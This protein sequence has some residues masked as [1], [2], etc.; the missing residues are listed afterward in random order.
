MS[1]SADEVAFDALAFRSVF[2]THPAGVAVVTLDGPDGPTGFT[3]TSVVSVSADPPIVLFT[4]MES[5]SN[6]PALSAADTVVIHFLGS[7]HAE[8][9]RRFS[10]SGIDRF[11][12]LAWTPLDR[13]EPLIDGVDTWMR[14]AVLS[15]DRA[16]GS[17]VVQ[18]EPLECRVSDDRQPLV[19]HDRRYH[20]LTDDSVAEG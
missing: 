2:R 20:R 4:I 11:E 14:C 10:T 13:G 7:E 18:V 6:W 9:S 3:A 12:G 16:G 15:R 17:Y 8:I 19:Y 5:S 1:L